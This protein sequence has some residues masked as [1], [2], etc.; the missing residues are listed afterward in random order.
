M[1]IVLA[2]EVDFCSFFKSLIRQPPFGLGGGG[3]GGEK[4]V[5]SCEVV[6]SVLSVIYARNVRTVSRSF[7]GAR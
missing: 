5:S 7:V 2:A 1:M 3:A 4:C 6:F